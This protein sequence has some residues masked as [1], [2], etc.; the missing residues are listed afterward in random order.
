MNSKVSASAQNFVQMLR[1]SG[2]V[3]NVVMVGGGIA[4][5]QA[6]AIA[7]MPFLTRLY[8][9]EAFGIAAA[10]AAII[11][12]I[13]PIATLGYANAIVMPAADDDAA[14]V[15]RLS[16]VCC[17]FI[18]PVS[19]IVIHLGRPWLAS[20]TGMEKT[21]YMLYLIPV[22]LLISAFLSVA[23]QAAIREG[24][25]KAKARAYIESTALTNISKLTGG[26][27]A[28]TG[29]V[30]IILTLIGQ[31][32]NFV[33]Q[34]LRMPRKGVLKPS[35]WFGFQ[36]IRAAA[37][38]QRDFAIYR[39]PHGILHAA[40]YGLPVILLSTLF[41]A[42]FAGQYSLSVLILGAPSTLLGG[43]VGEVFYPKITRAISEKSPD[44]L[45]L[46]TKVTVVLL[47]VGILPF[48]IIFFWGDHIV[49]LIF[50][51]EW[52]L[53]GQ[54]SQWLSLWFLTYLVADVSVAALPILRLQ[55]FLLI[56]EMVAVVSRVAAL[57]VGFAVFESDIVAI[58]LFSIVGVILSLSV[59][60]VTF[61]RLNNIHEMR[62]T[63]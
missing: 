28:P 18:V 8:G 6:I 15:I 53:A 14:A 46:L 5:A 31:A 13:T 9:P 1:T 63:D 58:I 45:A 30:L 57:Y 17:L 48:G 2:F 7:F 22:S 40:S 36:G 29:L 3:R 21:P 37:V 43:A 32:T 25:F 44:S 34:M 47:G 56:R 59:I 62:V 38:S 50:G 20:L 60:Y 54:Y 4:A 26:L 35:N 19:L 61:R 33:V 51:A 16:L 11:S 27:L 23:N 24:L 39:L 55:R 12:I 49:S 42:S 41:G 52:V 10:F